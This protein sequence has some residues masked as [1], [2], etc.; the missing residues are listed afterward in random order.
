ML[1]DC[2]KARIS[3]LPYG[4]LRRNFIKHIRRVKHC[5]TIDVWVRKLIFE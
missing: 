5:E 3:T 4:A 2:R 1:S